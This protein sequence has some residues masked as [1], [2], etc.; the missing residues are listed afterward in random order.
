MPK[1]IDIKSS[2][3]TCSKCSLSQV[4]LPRGLSAKELGVLS[5][6]VK[7]EHLFSKG[8]AVYEAGQSFNSLYAIRSGSVKVLLPTNNG[9]N[10]IVGFHMP[11]KLLGFDG[12]RHGNHCCTAIALESTSVCE[13]PYN[14]L[15]ELAIKL[16]NLGKRLISL[17]SDEITDDHG[18]LLMLTKK[19]AEARLATFLLN[20]STCFKMRGFSA[21]KFNLRMSRNDI[22]NYLGLAVETVSRIMTHMQDKGI[23]DVNRR[24]VNIVNMR[25]LRIMADIAA[26]QP[27]LCGEIFTK[28][29]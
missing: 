24:F 26:N 1:V 19:S 3:N 4:C 17:M 5:T 2:K 18:Q 6:L 12:M 8:E 21:E 14:Q 20:L 27:A 13:L 23:I 25:D 7:H 9:E 10:K 22:A 16:P 11:G 28:Q 29:S 15:L